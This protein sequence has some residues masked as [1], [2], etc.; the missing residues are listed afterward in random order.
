MAPRSVLVAALLVASACPIGL[1]GPAPP[2]S[3][4]APGPSAAETE[5]ILEL[6]MDL[7]VKKARLDQ[8]LAWLA[9]AAHKRGLVIDVAAEGV[10]LGSRTV[11][12]R[13]RQVAMGEILRLILGDDL[14]WTVEPGRV[15]V[16]P[17]GAGGPELATEML[18]LPR[19]VLP[20]QRETWAFASRSFA[21]LRDAPASFTPCD[22]LGVILRRL[23]NE[24]MYPEV[25]PWKDEGGK[26][27]LEVTPDAVRVTQTARGRRRVAEA[28]DLVAR[29]LAD[30]NGPLVVAPREPPAAADTR[31]TL[32]EATDQDFEHTSLDNILKYLNEVRKGLNLVVD[33]R[34]ASAGVDLS[35][36]DITIAVKQ[37]PVREFLDLV[38]GPDLGYRVGPGYVLVTI[39]DALRGPGV[40][41]AYRIGP[42]LPPD[43]PTGPDAAA[44]AQGHL[45]DL[46]R[47]ATDRVVPVPW[48]QEAGGD[49]AA[50]PLRGVLL[51]LQSLEGQNCVAGLLDG[52]RLAR[53][54][55][56]APPPPPAGRCAAALATRVDLDLAGTPLDK[57]VAYLNDLVPG[58]NLVFD[59]AREY[60]LA[61]RTVTLKV[62]GVTAGDALTQM[63]GPAGAWVNRGHYVFIMTA[64]HA[65]DCVAVGAY[66][67]A[68]A[69]RS[70]DGRA[71]RE[72]M[73]A[74][75]RRVPAS[76]S[77][78]VAPWEEDNGLGRLIPYGR[79]LVVVQTVE[80]HR[81]VAEE[82]R[83]LRQAEGPPAA[84][85][86]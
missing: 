60:E 48:D 64:E 34:L 53:A 76:G 18:P 26:A 29:A 66:P 62:R 13:V 23:V 81:L 36:R 9:A 79:V 50:V 49:A 25:A 38:L 10:D 82:L 44:D 86:P 58:S 35:T 32:E 71:E 43:L 31:R 75:R 51:V 40:L 21:R 14:A 22:Y 57:A 28:L 73:D 12:L 42:C 67:L 16:R 37:V 47:Q 27:A 46:V 72:M 30:P 6:P 19:G 52:L 77:P 2:E 70:A 20:T 41:R 24:S 59:P 80:G 78:C 39:R 65:Q 1:G 17:R 68:A 4:P 63:L 61:D 33:P 84:G 54:G 45:A 55:K 15:V 83:R 7:D 85:T 3:P 56:D 11:D 74:L 8:V 69:A 5:R